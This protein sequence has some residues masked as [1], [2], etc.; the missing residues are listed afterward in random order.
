METSENIDLVDAELVRFER[1]PTNGEIL[2]QIFRLVHTVKGTCGFLGLS[3]LEVLA[4]AAETVI[5]RLR[6]GASVTRETVSLI[7][8]TIDRIKLIVAAIDRTEAEPP[9]SDEDLISALET[10]AAAGR[11]DGATAPEA[12]TGTIVYQVL[13]RPLKPG[14]VSLD[15]LE[16]AF[17]ETPG[18]APGAT[19]LGLVRWHLPAPGDM[20]SPGEDAGGRRPR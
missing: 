3:R 16:R 9:G 19:S 18:P 5:G 15:D 11:G 1:E 13:E 8:E 7:L 17:R 12:V 6:E 4:H 20:R 2:A 10:A 14:E